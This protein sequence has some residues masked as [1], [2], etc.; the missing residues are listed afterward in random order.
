MNTYNRIKQC[1][2]TGKAQI[3]GFV[4]VGAP[5]LASSEEY[6]YQLIESG[7]NIVELGVAFSDPIAD[8]QVI[9]E[10]GNL[11]IANGVNFE[12]VTRLAG[13]IRK[14]YPAVGIVIFSYFNILLNYGLE[15]LP[16]LDIDGILAVDL[17]FEEREELSCHLR[18]SGIEIIPLISP[19]TTAERAKKIVADCGGFVYYIMVR[20]ITGTRSALPEDV[21]LKLDELRQ[22]TSLPI[23]GGF[24]VSTPLMARQVTEHADGVV[25]GSALVKFALRREFAKGVE[26]IKS[27][28]QAIN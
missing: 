22:L 11:A 24:G 6:I 3:V 19:V 4:T 7:V 9:Q 28:R 21:T 18:G 25:I 27:I 2:S 20:G 26:L 23:A 1:F 13:R 8:G 5:D 10:A 15:R 14:R 17:P 16:Q 12:D